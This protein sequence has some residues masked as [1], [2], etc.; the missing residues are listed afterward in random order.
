LTRLTSQAIVAPIADTVKPLDEEHSC[1]DRLPSIIAAALE[2]LRVGQ[3]TRAVGPPPEWLTFTA[4]ERVLLD[5]LILDAPEVVQS[6]AGDVAETLRRAMPAVQPFTHDADE[7][8]EFLV[9]LVDQVVD[10]EL[11]A[12]DAWG[13]GE[14][15]RE[16]RLDLLALQPGPRIGASGP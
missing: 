13:A 6:M 7:L 8:D 14:P 9:A 4:E 3:G 2:A 12:G 11:K 15:A 1:L 5:R 16:M 10:R